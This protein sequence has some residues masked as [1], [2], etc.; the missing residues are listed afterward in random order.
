MNMSDAFVHLHLHTQF[1][2]LDG[3][4]KIPDLVRKCKEFEM[5]AVAM[6]DHGNMFGVVEFYITAKKEGIKPIL[7]CEVYVAP[8]SRLQ[9][10]IPKGMG[11]DDPYYHLTILCMNQTGYKNLCRLITRANFEGFYYKPRIDKD[12]LKEHS[13]GLIILSGCL[14]GELAQTLHNGQDEKAEKLIHWYKDVFKDRFYFEVQ[15]NHL[16]EQDKLNAILKKYSQKFEVPLVGTGDC[17]YLHPE[18]ASA[19]EVLLCVQT[20]K[21]LDDESRMKFGSQ[22]FYFKEAALL[23]EEFLDFP[24]ASDN[25]LKIADLCDVNFELNKIYLPKIELPGK[26][27]LD[28]HLKDMAIQGFK[29]RISEWKK[30]PLKG[31]LKTVTQKYQ[32]RL[33]EELQIIQKTGFAGYF[34]IVSDFVNYAQKKGIPVGPGRGSAAGSLVAYCLRI[35]NIDP[36]PH[37]LIF[38]RFLNPERVS[39]P[40]MDIDFC[41][42]RRDEVIAYVT[43]KYGKENV[44]QIITFGKLQAKAAIRDVGRV[45]GFS[46]GEVD[47]IAKLVPNVLNISLKEAIEQEPKLKEF[48]EKD[49]RIKQLLNTAL[50]LEGLLRHAS[51]HAAGIVIANRPLVDTMPLFRGKDGEVVTSFDMKHVEKVGL[52]KFDFLGLKTLTLIDNVVRRIHEHFDP[53]FD[54]H[55][56][57]FTDKN[58]Y[59]LFSK[60][61]TVGVFQFESSGMREL[62]GKLK[63]A[64]FDDIIAANALYRP[65]PMMHLDNFIARRHG[66]VEVNYL[67]PQ[68]KDVLQ[69]SY[70]IIV[71]Q[72]QVMKIA[73]VLANYSLG[74]ADLLRRAMGK[75]NVSEMTRQKERF[76]KG[77]KEN[78]INLKKAEEIFE[79]MAKF[80]EYGFNKSHAQAYAY[81]AFQTAYLKHYYRLF[82]MS[83]MLTME[84]ENTDKLTRYIYDC[85]DAEIEILPPDVNESIFSFSVKD[86]KLRFGL[87]AIKNVG[88]IAIESVIEE[89]EKLNQFQSLR[90]FC[91]SVDLR[92]VNRKVVESLIKAGA[93][94]SVDTNRAKLMES[95]DQTMEAAQS[96]QADLEIGQSNLFGFEGFS[97]AQKKQMS[98]EPVPDWPMK[99]KLR[100]EKEATGLYITGHPLN[101]WKDALSRLTTHTIGDLSGLNNKSD[102]RVGGVI[103]ALRETITKRGDKMAFVMLEDL[104]GSCDVIIFSDLYAK[105]FDILKSDDPLFVSGTVEVSEENAK[106]IAS[107]VQ[108]LEN[109]QKRKTKRVHIELDEAAL[110]EPELES[111]KTTLNQHRGECPVLVHLKLKKDNRWVRTSLKTADSLRVVPSEA[112]MVDVDKIFKRRVGR[113]E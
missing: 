64:R 6:T 41:M 81:I 92:K 66:R 103:H 112:L 14:S 18:D 106:I 84:M 94:D 55:K 43:E 45:Y 19:Q 65:G 100:Y 53:Q 35:T 33:E 49:D 90:Q 46:Y 67:L 30:P 70:G 87:G 93:F 105:T 17:H 40:D 31:D 24:G 22:E 50:A 3:A 76:M 68:L 4:I 37:N 57:D 102:V 71:Y 59:E 77:A 25:T 13:E 82:F 29:D 16:H 110:T 104:T 108:T 88:Q 69:D 28:D 91:E 21:T 99:R 27:S 1:S 56:I 38:E 39:M 74:E 98:G 52:I 15:P 54:I 26:K 34:L 63:P 60:G 96:V 62:L 79:L 73:N 8:G 85:K 36:L 20:G 12:I 72:E 5:P 83:E 78:K 7:G 111:L 113:F 23:R 89:R 11:I 107:D 44:A 61:D 97:S 48:Y 32:S 42:N 109:A 47:R 95:L 80:A 10:E 75:K 86:E 9:K 58:V 51:I 2:L 101:N